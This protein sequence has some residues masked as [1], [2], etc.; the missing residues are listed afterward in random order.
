MIKMSKLNKKNI[1]NTVYLTLDQYE[2]N[3]KNDTN[4]NYYPLLA[5]DR[6]GDLCQFLMTCLIE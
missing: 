3:E 2:S 1:N 4:D 6:F 5:M